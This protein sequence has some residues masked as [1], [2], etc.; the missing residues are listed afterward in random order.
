MR[1]AS[2]FG[3]G[4]NL[5]YSNS[6]LADDEIRAVAPSIFAEA[7]H[8]SRSGRY[9]YIPTI[10][11]LRGLRKE[12]F[13]PFMACQTR[14]RDSGKRE[15]TK[16]MLRLRHAGQ[17]VGREVNE[18]IL[19]NSHDGTSSYQ[20]LAG[21]FR[22]VCH[23]GMICGEVQ[24]DI[25]VRHNG[26]VVGEVIEGA[27]RV[28]DSFEAITEQREAMQ[29]L[30]LND[31]EQAAF[32]RAAL[33]LKYDEVTAPITEDQIL[34]PRR[35]EDRSNDMWRTFNRV[36]ENLLKGGLRGRNASGRTTTTRPVNGIDQSVKLNRALW[37]LAEEMRKLKA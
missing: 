3:R 35:I 7:A 9:T 14:V 12:G 27:F 18:I 5:I 23:N 19:L 10:D 16:H 20:M 22:F 17:I 29:G 6:A 13:Q 31:G 37:V 28:L 26:D 4:S 8:E 24:N 1:L 2:R 11:V 30:A 32:A 34:M 15:H 25:R 33:Q 36:Q 21:M